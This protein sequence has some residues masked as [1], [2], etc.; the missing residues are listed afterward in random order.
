[1]IYDTEVLQLLFFYVPCFWAL[2][3]MT[4]YRTLSPTICS[5][6]MG[7]SADLQ[8][9]L[10][11]VMTIDIRNEDIFAL[12]TFSNHNLLLL[13]MFFCFTSRKRELIH[14]IT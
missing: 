14:V 10:S 2:A 4:R 1:M 7:L 12:F 13:V 11:H 5:V 6:L 8:S 9:I 3:I